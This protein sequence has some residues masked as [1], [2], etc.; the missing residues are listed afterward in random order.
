MILLQITV[1]LRGI[2]PQRHEK[3]DYPYGTAMAITSYI[4]FLEE[5][6]SSNLCSYLFTHLRNSLIYVRHFHL[7]VKI[8]NQVSLVGHR[9]VQCKHYM[10]RVSFFVI[11]C[12]TY[13]P[14]IIIIVRLSISR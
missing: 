10:F 4:I 6:H 5:T 13:R 3:Q 9:S 12:N 2:G 7:K 8:M 11:L 14:F 1:V